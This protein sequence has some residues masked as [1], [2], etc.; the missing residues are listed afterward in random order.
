MGEFICQEHLAIAEEHKC[1]YCNKTHSFP[2]DGFSLNQRLANVLKASVHQ[3]DKE[4]EGYKLINELDLC[5][6]ELSALNNDP[7][8]YAFGYISDTINKIDAERER[9]IAEST[10]SMNY[11][12]A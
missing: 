10:E 1:T 12:M 9:L 5:I 4:K 3:C 7:Y 8:N 11:P 6:N 2:S